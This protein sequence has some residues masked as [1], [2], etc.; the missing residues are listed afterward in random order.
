MRGIF[1]D[2]GIVFM[3]IR[4]FLVTLMLF[5]KMFML[6]TLQTLFTEVTYRQEGIYISDEV[7]MAVI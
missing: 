5:Y 3:I 6:E 4:S 1:D 7:I 2:T